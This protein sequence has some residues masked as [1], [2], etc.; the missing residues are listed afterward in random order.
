MQDFTLTS[1]V[2]QYPERQPYASIKRKILGARYELSLVFIGKTRAITL[3]RKSRHKT[4]AP[5]V[6]AF[7]LTNTTG[8]VFICPE[9]ANREAK[10]FGLSA[11]GY[12]AYLFIHACLHLKGHEHGD[13]MEKLERKYTRAFGIT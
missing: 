6:L 8:E 3:N 13:T 1:T 5:N 11:E 12:I 4:Y 9:A 10:H 7:P 2:K